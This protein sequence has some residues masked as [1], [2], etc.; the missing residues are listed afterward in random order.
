MRS[1]LAA[2]HHASSKTL[3]I[4]FLI[5]RH[6]RQVGLYC[7][8]P[9]LLHGLVRGQFHAKYPDCTIELL[10]ED[11]L[12]CS[13]DF[14]TWTITLHLRPDLFPI[15]RYQQFEEV[16]HDEVDDPMGA[17]CR[18]WLRTTVTFRR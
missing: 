1:I 12:D 16:I 5:G 15:L 18:R 6:A 9:G 4:S 3:P 10:E 13:A 11:A 7:R 17:C 8:F 14:E 2:I